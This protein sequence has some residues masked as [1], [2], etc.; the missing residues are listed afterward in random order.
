MI[1]ELEARGLCNQERLP[2][3]IAKLLRQ[4][5]EAKTATIA[6]LGSSKQDDIVQ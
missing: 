5:L 1:T 3:L 6:I 4:F 2:P